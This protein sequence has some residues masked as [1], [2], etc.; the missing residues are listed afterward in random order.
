MKDCPAFSST[1]RGRERDSSDSNNFGWPA[2]NRHR[3]INPLANGIQRRVDQQRMPTDHTAGSHAAA[4]ADVDFDRND[5]VNVP[6]LSDCRILR[7]NLPDKPPL[8]RLRRHWHR[9]AGT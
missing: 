1:I 3:P 2:A 4:R 6:L 7:L 9:F 5:A 8:H